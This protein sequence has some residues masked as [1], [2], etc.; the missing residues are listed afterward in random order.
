VPQPDF[1][2]ADVIVRM[3]RMGTAMSGDVVE[4]LDPS[5]ARNS[6][7]ATLLRLLIDDDLRPVQLIETTG[8]SRGGMT[9]VIDQLEESG[10]VER[11]GDPDDEDGRS[12]HI[13][14]TDAGRRTASDLSDIMGAHVRQFLAEANDIL[15]A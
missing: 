7:A 6:V 3:M 8:L 9:K 13:R 2:I 15:G 5:L 1:P 10:L 12:V 14:L 4:V 11:F